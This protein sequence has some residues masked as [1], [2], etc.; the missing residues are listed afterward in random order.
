M[1]REEREGGEGRRLRFPFIYSLSRRNLR[2]LRVLRAN[3]SRLI[4]LTSR[5]LL[6]STHGW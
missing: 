5:F 2:F 3:S 4:D 6:N 1:S